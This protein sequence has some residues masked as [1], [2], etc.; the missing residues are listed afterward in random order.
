MAA[1]E[2]GVALAEVEWY[3]AVDAGR[4]PSSAG[5]AARL[6][7]CIPLAHTAA[8]VELQTAQLVKLRG[9]GRFSLVV[10]TLG[11]PEGPVQEVVRLDAGW[12]LRPS[13]PD[14]ICREVCTSKPP[15][16]SLAAVAAHGEW[17]GEDLPLYLFELRR[18]KSPPWRRLLRPAEAGG[19]ERPEGEPRKLRVGFEDQRRAQEW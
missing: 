16:E 7:S 13:A 10:T 4:A 17:E 19:D 2:T 12:E 14:Q 18:R 5:P 1:T 8:I 6:L 11:R 3:R 15:G 9:R